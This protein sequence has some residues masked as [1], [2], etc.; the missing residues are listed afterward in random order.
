MG[1]WTGS[2][3]TCAAWQLCVAAPLAG[4]ACAPCSPPMLGAVPRRVP[5]LPGGARPSAVSPL[6]PLVQLGGTQELLGG[7]GGLP[8]G[9]LTLADCWLACSR[10]HRECGILRRTERQRPCP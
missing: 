10:R 6:S 1:W 2:R 9:P 7:W 3:S 8:G 4:T 5:H